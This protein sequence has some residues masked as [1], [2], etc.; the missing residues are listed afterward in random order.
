MRFASYRIE[1]QA[2]YGLVHEGSILEPPDEFRARFPDLRNVLQAGALAEARQAAQNGV[3]HSFDAV[4]FEPVIPHPGKILC[5]GANYLTHMKEMGRV[6]PEYPWL[7]VRF[8]DSQVG[9]GQPMIR[10]AAS[11]KYDFEGELA[12]IIG[13]E[14]RHIAKENALDYVAGYSCFNDGT[15][16]DFQEHGSQFTPGKNFYHSGSFGPWLVTADEIP[17]P[18]RL[19]LKTRLNG[20]T[21]QTALISDLRF[22][23]GE[24]IEYCSTFSRLRP[25]DVIST[26]TTGGVGFARKPPVW[27]EPGDVIEVEISGI[28]VLRNAIVDEA[29]R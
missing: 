28:G 27:M 13:R 24:L 4:A 7:F 5:V 14:A 19:T 17:D 6:V 15:L 25:G 29:D 2:A 16:R 12:V 23:I 11:D 21:M 18:T 26:G 22:G 10:P 3:Q 20:Q 1:G 9:H 8:A